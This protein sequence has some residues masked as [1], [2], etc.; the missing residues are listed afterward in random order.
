MC[1]ICSQIRFETSVL[2]SSLRDY[3]DIYI[4]IYVNNTIT[5]TGGPNDATDTNKRADKKKK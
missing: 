3:S 2:K 5:I 1:S 4:Y